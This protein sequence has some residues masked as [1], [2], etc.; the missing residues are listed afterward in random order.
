MLKITKNNYEGYYELA[1][2]KLQDCQNYEMF[3]KRFVK[4]EL[5]MFILFISLI[6]LRIPMAILTLI[7]FG[8]VMVATYTNYRKK[9]KK[10][11]N[12][13][14]YVND[15]ITKEELIKEL[16]KTNILKYEKKD[17]VITKIL[18]KEGYLKLLENTKSKNEYIE[19]CEEIK[20]EI[21]ND[22]EIIQNDFSVSNEE[23]KKVKVKIKTLNRD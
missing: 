12:K 18:D 17:N 21:I 22:Y 23:L 9:I 7:P 14:P 4:I 2:I 8:T 15:K 11:K 19:K 20:K 1:K 13:Y 5:I 3:A 6:S 16:E 10:L